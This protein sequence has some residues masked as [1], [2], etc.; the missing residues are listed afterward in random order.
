MIRTVVS[1]CL[2]G[3]AGFHIANAIWIPVK[4]NIAQRLVESAWE[5]S[6]ANG[7]TTKPWPWADTWP[8]GRLIHKNSNTNLYILEGA[9][10]NALAF[11]PGRH[12]DS[13]QLGEGTSVIGGHRDTHFA[14]LKRVRPSEEFLIQTPAGNWLSYKVE[15]T[16]VVNIKDQQLFIVPNSKKII[17]VT[18]YPFG[19]IARTNT[20]RFVVQL[21]PV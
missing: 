19:Q 7:K 17:L 18:C 12:I 9:Q 11:G 2:L 21:V 13:S 1:L 14:F 16:A 6:L 5:S 10:G 15:N 4:A 20:L 3:C 8:V